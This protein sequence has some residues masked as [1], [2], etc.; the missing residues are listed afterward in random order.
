M[1]LIGLIYFVLSV[2]AIIILSVRLRKCMKKN[3]SEPVEPVEPVEPDD[4][5]VAENF[6]GS[7]QGIGSM[8]FRNPTEMSRLY[9][10]GKLTE[11]TPMPEPTEWK[12]TCMM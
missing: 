3:E 7:C 5:D 10:E 8:T 1:L 12:K 11:F 9:E 4:S 2:A 6:C